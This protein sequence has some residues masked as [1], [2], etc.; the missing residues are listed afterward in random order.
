MIPDVET[1]SSRGELDEVEDILEEE[2]R[3]WSEFTL[4]GLLL[5]G[6]EAI[7][8]WLVDDKI[9]RVAGLDRLSVAAVP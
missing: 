7:S 4:I 5:A 2:S 1:V 3:L 9:L 8:A 6:I